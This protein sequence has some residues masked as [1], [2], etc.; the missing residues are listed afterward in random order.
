MNT[1]PFVVFMWAFLSLP[2]KDAICLQ[3]KDLWSRF[4]GQI[5]LRI[6]ESLFFGALAFIAG[7]FILAVFIVLLVVIFPYIIDTYLSPFNK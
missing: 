6:V 7:G 1:F 3:I 5:C 4:K 2:Y